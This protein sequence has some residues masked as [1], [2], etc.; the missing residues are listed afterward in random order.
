MVEGWGWVEVRRGEAEVVEQR[1]RKGE[2]RTPFLLSSVKMETG[3][4]GGG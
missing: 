4:G 1:K 3:E 2:H